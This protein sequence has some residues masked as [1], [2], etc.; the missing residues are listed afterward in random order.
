MQHFANFNVK[1]SSNWTLKIEMPSKIIDGYH[2]SNMGH[3][4]SADLDIF[5]SADHSDIIREAKRKFSLES[6]AS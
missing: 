1:F 3:N 4:R 6:E 5:T 2:Y